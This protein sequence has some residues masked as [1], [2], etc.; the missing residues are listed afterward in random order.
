MI[1]AAPAF[2]LLAGITAWISVPLIVLAALGLIYLVVVNTV[3][4]RVEKKSNTVKLLPP[5]KVPPDVQEIHNRMLIADL[6]ADALL[7]RRDLLKLEERG[8]VDIPRMIQ[9]NIAF[10][11]FGVVTK[12]PKGQNFESNSAK[13]FDNITLLA[14]LSAWPVQSWGSLLHRALYQANKLERFAKQSNGKLM[15]VLNQ[16]DL[17]MFLDLREAGQKVTAGFPC[18]EG[19]HALEGRVE[20]V[21]RLYRAGFRMI[22]MTHFF[23]NEA[24]GSAHGLEKAGL[25]DFGR[26]VVKRAQDLHMIIDLAHASPRMVDDVL[27]MTTAPVVASHTGVRGTCDNVRN[28]SDEHI[29]GIAR[30]GGVMGIAMFSQAVCDCSVEATA[31]AMRYTA[32][33]AGV[34]HVALGGDY[35]GTVEAP[36]DYRGMAL[37]TEAMLKEGFSEQDI[38]LILGLNFMRVLKAVLPAE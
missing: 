15:R 9:G 26:A 32:D 18:L 23:D 34:E 38:S 21:D 14:I 11:V 35:D 10:Q 8:H 37:L 25:T 36:V 24:G 31:R 1:D 13:A 20:N 6:H 4:I 17:Q 33:L 2:A 5:Y 30:T 28:L 27:A 19:T 22:G 29:R 7:W 16:K 12:S 3:P